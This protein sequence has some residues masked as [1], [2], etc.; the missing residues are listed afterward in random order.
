MMGS[1]IL[2]SIAVL[3][4]RERAFEHKLEDLIQQRNTRRAERRL[5][6]RSILS[7]SRRTTRELSTSRSTGAARNI[8]RGRTIPSHEERPAQDDSI[9]RATT[10]DDTGGA[11]ES[12]G[13][14]VAEKDNTP[15]NDEKQLP[16]LETT[17]LSP[18]NVS[19]PESCGIQSPVQSP[20]S[21][22]GNVITGEHVTFEDPHHREQDLRSQTGRLRR[23]HTRL[24]TGDG[25]GVRSSLDAHPREA[26]PFIRLDKV[27]AAKKETG[28]LKGV[29][30]YIGSLNGL[31]GRNSQFYNLSEDER[32]QLGG[33]EYQAVKLLSLVVPVY[34]IA[35]Q[36]LGAVSI[37]AWMNNKRPSLAGQNGLNSYWTGAFFAISA[38]NNSGMALLDANAT[39]LQTAAYPLLTMSLLILAGNT[40]FPPFLRLILWTLEKIVLKFCPE[41]EYWINKAATLRFILNHPRRVFTNLFPSRQTWWLVGSLVLLNGTDWIFFEV[42]SIGNSAVETIPA[43]YRALDGLFQAFAVRSGGFYVVAISNLRQGL[44]I[45]YVA[46]MYISVY[47]VTMTIRTTNVYEERSLNIYYSDE[48]QLSSSERKS[49]G[50]FGTLKRSMSNAAPTES[51]AYFIRQQLRGQLAHDIWWLVVAVWLI[52][53][54]ESGQYDRDPIVFSTFNIVF[55]CVSG[56]GTVGISTGVPWN[57]YSFCG[58]WHKLSKLVL[59]AVMLRGRH[60]GL[61]VAIDRAVL[62]PDKTLA[63]AEEEDAQIKH[64][65]ADRVALRKY[66]S[67]PVGV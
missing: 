27:A 47:P 61:P 63:W 8:F 15:S 39:A 21:S 53:I 33:L 25:V 1:A 42:L 29:N 32:E 56:Y 46:M 23:S 66:T 26:N 37:G 48:K 17:G 62:L 16:S 5:R 24:F 30:R 51:R 6:S 43:N 34:Y 64:N 49:M 58:A 9:T 57:A 59:C 28:I 55:E 40:C 18:H 36:L 44:L 65:K 19:Q 52:S 13:K 11:D 67:D 35:W 45:L 14:S 4:V 38:F 7:L 41:S 12:E 54:I 2:M 31:I 3:K 20:Q 50:F 22:T 10:R 60:R